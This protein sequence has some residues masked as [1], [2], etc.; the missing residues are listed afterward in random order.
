VTLGSSTFKLW[1]TKPTHSL[2]L[3]WTAFLAVGYLN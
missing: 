3:F 2:N 1:L